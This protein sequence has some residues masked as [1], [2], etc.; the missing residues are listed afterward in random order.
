MNFKKIYKVILHIVSL[1][2]RKLNPKYLTD[3]YKKNIDH[4]Q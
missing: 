2:Y 3:T 1:K 4:F